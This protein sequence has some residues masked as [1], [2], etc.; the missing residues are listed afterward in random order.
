MEKQ[1][2]IGEKYLGKLE[3]DSPELKQRLGKG[4]V[5]THISLFSGA[6]GLDL[7]FSKAGIET[8]VMV[9]WDKSCCETLRENWHWKRL[10]KRSHWHYETKEGKVYKG[11]I[12]TGNKTKE[13]EKLKY[14]EDKLRWKNKKEF[15]QEAK[16]YEKELERRKKS[17][18]K[19]DD[20]Y[21]FAM[22]EP[23]ATWYHER[24]P[25][26][27]QKDIKEV[28]TKELLNAAGLEIGECSIISGGF[29]CQGFSTAGKRVIDDPRN[30]LYKE[31]VRIVDEAKPM[32]IMGENVPGIV[33]MG[34]GEVMKQICQD[35]AN[36]G[37]DITWD[38]LNA[39]D[40]GVPQIRKRVILIGKRIDLLSFN[41]GRPSYHLGA[42]P[43]K[44]TH[45]ELFYKRLKRWK[46]KL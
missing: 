3:L 14:V 26:I 30:F 39:A 32:M 23:P 45:P 38:I 35:F 8:R 33:S 17:N 6:G 19:R 31:F 12:F 15:L 4:K 25:V 10:K 20:D 34:K 27:I 46:K 40:Y 7:G 42:M 43:G 21:Q 13:G 2:R 37:Y 36:C 16:D 44:I 9:E 11:S 1:I 28:T 24:E 29:P 18:K 41:E 22:Q 5:T